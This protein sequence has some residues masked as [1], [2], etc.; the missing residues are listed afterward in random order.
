MQPYQQYAGQ[1]MQYQQL[2]VAPAPSQNMSN[3]QVVPKKRKKKKN[4]APAQGPAMV[5]NAAVVPQ[6]MVWV[7]APHVP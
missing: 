7:A 1:Y 3:P 2:G 5:A 4:A 6:P